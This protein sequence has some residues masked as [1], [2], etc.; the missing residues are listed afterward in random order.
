MSRGSRGVLGLLPIGG[1]HDQ[2]KSRSQEKTIEPCA[3][4]SGP[5]GRGVLYK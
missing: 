2:R 1:S 3:T 4:G 5:I